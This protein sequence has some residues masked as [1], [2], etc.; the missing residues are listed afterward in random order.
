M[1]RHEYLGRREKATKLS[2]AMT[3]AKITREDAAVM[4]AA[5]WE[6]AALAAGV[7]VPSAATIAVTLKM[8]ESEIL[9]V[10]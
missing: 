2:A 5:D 4:T 9:E 10:A 6:A 1:S 7:N 3:A 8:L